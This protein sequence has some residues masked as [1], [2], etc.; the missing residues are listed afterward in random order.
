MHADL[1]AQVAELW[2]QPLA[3]LKA[4]YAEL[5]A[6]RPPS[7]NRSWLARRIAW[8]LQALAHGDLSERAR[9][10]A[11]ELANEADLRLSPP[12]HRATAVAAAAGPHKTSKSRAGLPPPGT[13]VR[14][15]YKGQ[16]LEIK[17]LENGCQFDGRVYGSLSAVAK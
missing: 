10:R 15:P 4:R 11:L 8:R 16:V 2:R 5:F 1:E 6:E 14:R 3:D 12:R 9:Q 17:I 7:G 13:I